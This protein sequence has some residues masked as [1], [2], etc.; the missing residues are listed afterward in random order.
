M[1]KETK[2]SFYNK[3][4]EKI[5]RIAEKEI[6]K[7]IE[8]YRDNGDT[9]YSVLTYINYNCKKKGSLDN[10][11]NYIEMHL[12]KELNKDEQI[13]QQEMEKFENEYECENSSYKEKYAI[14]QGI[15]QEVETY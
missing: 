14:L 9:D 3:W 8:I 1:N 15:I 11:N 10:L 13:T 2:K 12:N 7:F 5:E 4:R 6:E